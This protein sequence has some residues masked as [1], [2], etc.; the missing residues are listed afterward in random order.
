MPFA[1]CVGS[2]A[3]VALFFFFL[4]A[5]LVLL[6]CA[7]PVATFVCGGGSG[8]CDLTPHAGFGASV[9]ADVTG[10]APSAGNS[11]TLSTFKFGA[12]PPDC[13]FCWVL[14]LLLSSLLLL[15]LPG[16]PFFAFLVVDDDDDAIASPMDMVFN[17]GLGFFDLFCPIVVVVAVDGCLGWDVPVVVDSF[18][19]SCTC[20]A[21]FFGCWTCFLVATDG[22]FELAIVVQ[23]EDPDDSATALLGVIFEAT[24][25]AAEFCL[26]EADPEAVGLAALEGVGLPHV[27]ELGIARCPSCRCGC[28]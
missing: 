25:A 1:D 8:A 5:L 22:R 13:C 23:A 4:L 11:W 26:E 9:A 3:L 24:A 7:F 12:F 18:F 15:L 28:R 14:L 27:L 20:G 21:F 17:L 16:G 6:F 10:P 19:N 2:L